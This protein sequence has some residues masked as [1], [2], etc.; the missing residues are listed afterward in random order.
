MPSRCWPSAAGTNDEANGL[1]GRIDAG[2]PPTLNAAPVATVTAPSGL[3]TGTVAVTA[4]AQASI[5]IAK[6][7]FFANGASLGTVTTSPYTVQWDTTTVANGTVALTATATDVDGNVGTSPAVNV[8]VGNGVAVQTL[9]QLQA[10]IF[11]PKCSGCHTGVGAALPGSQN[12][13]TVANTYAA[14]V[15]VA[16]QEVPA[17]M[18]V[19]PGDPTNS[20]VI[21]KLEGA[22]D[23]TGVR[24]PAG[25]PY[26]DQ[27]TI[28]SIKNW[29]ASGAPNN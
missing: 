25:G 18:R 6:V 19:K 15:N 11:G 14:L 21:H 17:L 26:L 1:Y 9:T 29:I 3:V 22:A 10:A 20:Y 2:G 28:D 13:T 27:A 5:A 8:T 16:S 23:I 4:T 12:L 7:Q 24:M